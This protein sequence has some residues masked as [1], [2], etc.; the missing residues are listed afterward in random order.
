MQVSTFVSSSSTH[1]P[2][3]ANPSQD[4]RDIGSPIF[5]PASVQQRLCFAWKKVLQ[6]QVGSSSI[7]KQAILA[8]DFIQF[9]RSPAKPPDPL[10]RPEVEQLRADGNK[11][12]EVWRVWC[13]GFCSF[14][15]S[16][17]TR[18]EEIGMI[19]NAIYALQ[20]CIFVIF[21][22]YFDMRWKWVSRIPICDLWLVC[23]SQVCN[24]S[25]HFGH[26]QYVILMRS[27]FSPMPQQ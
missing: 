26:Q 1:L 6:S 24:G 13:P 3:P 15:M 11:R 25:T 14:T 18:A 8:N 10:R 2:S 17:A 12:G 5:R 9:M 27:V 19:F 7:A 22:R 23:D 20:A 4:V 16:R 21:D